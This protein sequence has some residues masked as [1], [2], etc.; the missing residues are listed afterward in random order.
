MVNRVIGKKK[1]KGSGEKKPSFVY[2]ER[3]VKQIKARAE[4]SGGR[5]DSPFVGNFDTFRP[6]QGSSQIR[7]LPPTWDDYD[8]YGLD[9]WVHPFVGPDN[10]TYICP[11]K[12]K[13]KPCPICAAAEEANNAGEKDEAKALQPQ[14]RV[15]V[16]AI[17]RDAE[18]EWPQLYLMS[19]SQDK[20]IV[21]RSHNARSGKTKHIDHP[22]KGHDVIINRSGQGL[23]TRYVIEIDS[24][25]SPISDDP[26]NQ[27]AILEFIS[28]N[29]LPATLK[30]YDAD[31][32]EKVISGTAESKDEDL[33]EDADEDEDENPK[34]RGSKKGKSGKK[35]RDEDEDDESEDVDEESEDEDEGEDED[36][37]PPRK[38]KK[39]AK[40][41]AK[42]RRDEDEDDEDEEDEEEEDDSDDSEDDDDSES[43]DEDDGDDE[44]D[45]DDS[46]EESEDEDS[47]DD[48]ESE[49]EEEPDDEDDSDDEDEESEDDEDEED[50]DPKPR[51]RV[52]MKAKPAGKK[53]R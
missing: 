36:D 38:P 12:M 45:D 23:K 33:D 46:E 16:W 6:K 39:P 25:S 29:P 22:D 47:E 30:Y 21:T 42:K 53:R 14:R 35:R 19:W 48:D 28:E 4:Q 49:D 20:D 1:A 15:L 13:N 41:P 10:S 44:S 7:I 5:F 27:D 40:K 32:L 31:Y 11:R 26:K 2:K 18:Q 9:V 52:K 51:G 37:T 24:D 43:E 3:S 34:S 17:D 8:H 50:E